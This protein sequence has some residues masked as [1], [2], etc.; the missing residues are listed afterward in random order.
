MNYSHADELGQ[1][2]TG[3]VSFQVLTFVQQSY[4]VEEYPDKIERLMEIHASLQAW[5][6]HMSLW[7]DGVV[8]HGNI[9]PVKVQSKS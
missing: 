4:T 1:A 7:D 3:T 9:D 5:R 8:P 2:L 6:D